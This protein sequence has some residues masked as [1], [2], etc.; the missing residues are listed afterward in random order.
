MRKRLLLLLL[1]TSL[2]LVALPATASAIIGGT[3]VGQP[4]PFVVSVQGSGG[5]HICGGALIASKWVVTAAHCG[6]PVQ[7]RIGSLN[8]TSGGTVTQVAQTI[9]HPSEDIELLRLATTVTHR[10]IPI[11]TESGPVGTPVVML[12]WG[13]TCPTGSCVEPLMLHQLTSTIVED[14]RC[15]GGGIRPPSEICVDNKGNTGPCSGDSGNPLA[16]H[17]SGAL[18]LIGV[19]SRT[20][21]GT[22]T[23]G[24]APSI[25]VDVP[26]LRTWIRQHTGV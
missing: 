6:T 20:G 13:R 4:H 16:K 25:H 17:V 7:V 19:Y 18:Q 1:T 9:R 12:G 8:R 14:S 21:R 22:P 5:R 2:A 23:C 24:A 15:A 11:A 26:Y 10:P 3:Q